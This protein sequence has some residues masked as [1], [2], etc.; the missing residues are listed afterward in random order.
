VYSTSDALGPTVVE[1]PWLLFNSLS[2]LAKTRFALF[3]VTFVGCT[4]VTHS[5][6]IIL[7]VDKKS[8]FVEKTYVYILVL[9]PIIIIVIMQII[10]NNTNDNIF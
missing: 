9:C 10:Y 1:P 5:L 8:E 7:F 3:R 4:C 2:I 6:I